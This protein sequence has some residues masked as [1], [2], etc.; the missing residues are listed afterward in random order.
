[1]RQASEERNS[2]TRVVYFAAYHKK[3]TF[4]KQVSV[5]ACLNLY[6]QTKIIFKYLQ[7]CFTSR[8][9]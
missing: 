9:M 5:V 6:S 8:D 2:L 4:R 7:I 1:M 3:T